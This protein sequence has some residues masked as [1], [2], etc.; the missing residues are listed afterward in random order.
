M[1]KV[2]ASF[3]DLGGGQYKV[4]SFSNVDDVYK[5]DMVKQTCDCIA[6]GM[7]RKRPCKHQIFI[8]NSINAKKV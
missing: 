8:Q 3:E 7:G 6:W 2:P 5:V 4:K 1:D